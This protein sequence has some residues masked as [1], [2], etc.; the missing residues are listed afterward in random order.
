MID[1]QIEEC[2]PGEEVK[3]GIFSSRDQED[4]GHEDL[5]DILYICMRQDGQFPFSDEEAYK[6]I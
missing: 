5:L 2:N 3:G 6:C 4:G 1:G